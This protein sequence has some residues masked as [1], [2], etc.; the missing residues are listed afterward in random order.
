[1]QVSWP[2]ART[3][4]APAAPAVEQKLGLDA[5]QCRAAKSEL[6]AASTTDA[7][8]AAACKVEILC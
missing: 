6:L 1:L 5:E 3:R 2:A 4:G 8:D 7:I